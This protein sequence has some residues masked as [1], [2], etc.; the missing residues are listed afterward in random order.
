[1]FNDPALASALS[2]GLEKAVNKTLKFDPGS[3]TKLQAL[4][5]KSVI[6]ELSEPEAMIKITIL[7]EELSLALQSGAERND[8]DRADANIKGKLKDLIKFANYRSRS[9][10]G[11]GIDIHGDL[12]FMESFQ[13]ILR[14][15]DIDWEDALAE[16]IGGP[17]AHTLMQSVQ[18]TKKQLV[19]SLPKKERLNEY[20]TN[21]IALTPS[22][23]EFIQFRAEISELRDACDRL[24]AKTS[25]VDHA[26]KTLRTKS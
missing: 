12:N 18:A 1:M 21:E 5:G 10:A 7:G 22:R 2:W 8:A 4:S 24:T 9:L 25:I 19:N 23:A 15:L 26:I 17:A 20:L 13:N 3:R 14:Q 6:I 16:K 11:T